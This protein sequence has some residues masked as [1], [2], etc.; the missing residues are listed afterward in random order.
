MFCTVLGHKTLF[1]Q[2]VSCKKQAVPHAMKKPRAKPC[3]KTCKLFVSCKKQ[4]VPHVMQKPCKNHANMQKPCNMRRVR[5]RLR[6]QARQGFYAGRGNPLNMARNFVVCGN[7]SPPW[8]I[9]ESNRGRSSM[10]GISAFP[11]PL[12]VEGVFQMA[13]I[14]PERL[15]A[16]AVQ[17]L[18][19]SCEGFEV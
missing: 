19:S 6:R 18:T 7:K 11:L 8:S 3:E 15:L 5:W 4:A 2:F 17:H 13:D 1:F 10:Q 9:F 12:S 14:L 16:L